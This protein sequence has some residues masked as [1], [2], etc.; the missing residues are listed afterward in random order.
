LNSIKHL[1]VTL[2]GRNLATITKYTGLDP[3]NTGAF[4]PTGTTISGDRSGAFSGVDYYG[5]PNLRSYQFSLSVG[6]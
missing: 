4:S 6:F 5:V 2:S 3:E 1:T